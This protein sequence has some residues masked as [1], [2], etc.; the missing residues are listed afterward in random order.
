MYSQIALQME[1]CT[2]EPGVPYLLVV[3]I[4]DLILK[5]WRLVCTTRCEWFLIHYI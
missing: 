2:L 3:L 5:E 1:F 4:Y